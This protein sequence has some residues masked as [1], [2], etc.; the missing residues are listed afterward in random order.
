MKLSLFTL[1]I[2]LTA[3]GVTSC[4][5]NQ[6]AYKIEGIFSGSFSANFED[7]IYLASEGHQVKFTPLTKNNVRVEGEG[8]STFEFLVTK[9]GLNVVRVNVSDSNLTKFTWIADEDRVVFDYSRGDNW[10]TFNGTR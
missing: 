10:C 3:F 6:P 4:K 2:A 7:S 8:F 5:K 9:D 1:F